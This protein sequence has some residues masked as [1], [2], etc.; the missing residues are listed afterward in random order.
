M[1]KNAPTYSDSLIDFAIITALEV[2]RKAVCNVFELSDSNRVKIDSR[3]YW[4]GKLQLSNGKFYEIVVAQAPDMANIDAALLTSDTLH[5]WKPSAALM[6]GI[7]AS[8]SKEL[9]LGDIVT[10][11]DIYYYERGKITPEGKK[12]EPKIIPSDS[13]L[14]ANVI[15]LPKWNPLLPILR[16]DELEE[17][18]TVHQ[19]VIASGEKVIV[20]EVV[21]DGIT[22]GH[23]KIK[24]IEMEGYGFS[25][26]VWQSFEHVR[27]LVIR[28][29]SDDA[30]IKNDDWHVY[31]ASVAA[32]FTKYFLQDIP[33]EPRNIIHATSNPV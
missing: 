18:P 25:R 32:S 28:A 31:A 10:A 14:W 12:P 2:E 1:I 9:K 5:H 8:A 13:T 22:S 23:R 17:T 33:L 27:S 20:D 16:P 4:R 26:A 15:T 21:R 3:V 7:A 24:A 11:S 29:I 6:V 30:K 19:G